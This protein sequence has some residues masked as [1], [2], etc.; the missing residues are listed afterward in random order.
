MSVRAVVKDVA[1][2]T[3]LEDVDQS[4]RKPQRG[5]YLPDPL[6]HLGSKRLVKADLGKRMYFRFIL[7]RTKRVGPELADVRRP[8]SVPRQ[9]LGL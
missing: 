9:W 2:R 5:G 3:M 7:F 1:S 4:D 6:S 8:T